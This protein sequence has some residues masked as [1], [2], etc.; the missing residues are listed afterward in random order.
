MIIVDDLDRCADE[1]ALEICQ[2]A[3]KLLNHPNVVTVLVGDLEPLALATERQRESSLDSNERTDNRPR[4][5]EFLRVDQRSRMWRSLSAMRAAIQRGWDDIVWSRLLVWAIL[6]I[7]VV[8]A[9]L[10]LAAVVHAIPESTA[11]DSST[12]SLVHFVAPLS[13]AII[14]TMGIKFLVGEIR[15]WRASPVSSSSP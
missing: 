5:R 10:L 4:G 14:G 15:V 7:P 12:T 11:D 13:A 9:L 8:A 1:R 2:V 6:A 3:A